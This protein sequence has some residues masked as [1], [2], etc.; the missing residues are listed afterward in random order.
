MW[1]LGASGSRFVACI[2]NAIIVPLLLSRSSTDSIQIILSGSFKVELLATSPSMS[3][4][5]VGAHAS[6]L[7]CD[8][9]ATKSQTTHKWKQA[10]VWVERALCFHSIETDRI[11]VNAF[12]FIFK[13]FLLK[14]VVHD[15]LELCSTGILI[16]RQ[17]HLSLVLIAFLWNCF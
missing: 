17:T 1:L 3:L 14:M 16:V 8:S 7:S 10:I 13:F 11:Y 15:I 5:K 6:C 2:G 9:S 4:T 12:L